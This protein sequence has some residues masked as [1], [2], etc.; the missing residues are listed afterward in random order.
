MHLHHAAFD[1][2]ILGVS[3]DY[4]V[5]IRHVQTDHR[6]RADY[7]IHC[8]HMSPHESAGMWNSTAPEDGTVV[9]TIYS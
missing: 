1:C 7:F 4:R 9:P 2:H 3:P 6:Y 8:W 5:E